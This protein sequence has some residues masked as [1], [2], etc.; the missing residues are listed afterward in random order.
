[1][2]SDNIS[3]LND[4]LKI[5]S[6]GSF[7]AAD[8]LLHCAKLAPVKMREAKVFLPDD[9][10]KIQENPSVSKMHTIG[11]NR[12]VCEN[13]DSFSMARKIKAKKPEEDVLVINFANPVHPG[14]GVKKGSSAQEEDL[15]RKSSLLLSL[16]SDEAKKYYD[17]NKSMNTYM[18]SDAIILSPYVE[19]FKDAKGN[20][21]EE[22]VVVSVLTCAA[23]MI[24]YG[25][26][27]M[28]QDEYKQMLYNR[29]CGMMTVALEYGYENIVWGAWG[30]GAFGNDAAVMADIFHKAF[31]E[32]RYN[33]VGSTGLFRTVYFA[34]LDRSEDLYNF[35]EF[36]RNFDGDNY[37]KAEDDAEINETLDRI[38]DKEKNLDKIKGCI[39][40]GAIG[41][42]LGYPIEFMLEG[43]IT[44][45]Y[46]ESGIT[47]YDL[48]KS[49][50][51]LFSDDTQM[52]LFT[53][54]GIMVGD[55]RIC[56]RGIGAN[57]SNYVA[58]AYQDWLKTQKVSFKSYEKRTDAYLCRSWLCDVPELFS[59]REP[60]NTCLS[61][62]EL[63][64]QTDQ[65]S[66]G[67]QSGTQP[68]RRR[69][70][71]EQPSIDNPVNDSK[72]CGG[73]MR[74]APLALYYAIDD[75]KSLDREG[76]EIAAITHGHSLGYMPAAVL[77]HIISRIVY[78]GDSKMSLKEIV[79]EAK[80]TVDGI[81]AGDKHLP[82][83]DAIIDK[84]VE[85]SENNKSDLDNI[86]T[87]GE[88]WVAEETLA[89]AIYC[90]LKYQNDFSAGVIAAV[91]HNGDSDSTGAVTGNI[92]GALLGYDR[93]E[94]KWKNNLELSNVL[95]EISV[96]LC[97]GCMMD[98]YGHYRDDDWLRKYIDMQ[99]KDTPAKLA[100]PVFFWK[101]NEENGF[102]SNWYNAPFVIDDFEY[103][104]VEQY[105][106]SQKAKM[107][108]DSKT[109][110]A[111]LKA[112]SPS[113]C[114][115]LGK[116]VKPFVSEE[117]AK[118]RGSVC[119]KATLEKFNQNPN[120]KAMLLA[121]GNAILEEASP[122]DKIWGIGLDADTAGKTSPDK[123]PGE[124][125][126]GRV[127]MLVRAQLGGGDISS[128][129]NSSRFDAM[130]QALRDG[131]I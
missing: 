8:G 117:W 9:I 79:I 74:V 66:R 21:L 7:V 12:H 82:E 49:G 26:E 107:F 122:V 41:D 119:M 50:K 31:D 29:I 42:A 25:L 112:D 90:S 81:F 14:G 101:N 76:A 96:D 4:T 77:T 111:I 92:L 13:T 38:E 18:G 88:G 51:A 27:G 114:K 64:E 104:N 37:Y 54:N 94:D 45:Q 68:P 67:C 100:E 44:G 23:P 60:G 95:E 70:P 86:H 65:P 36:A 33:K 34:V 129:I 48:G 1:M 15:C 3:M 75:M 78:P 116:A 24:T 109:Y 58:M 52:T 47:E 62:L 72:G 123:W 80:N 19:I 89:I 126:L 16:E 127:L 91:N 56:M 97:H 61:A 39:F 121:T 73:I 83:L 2:R 35:K 87:L 128:I 32:F 103:Q 98:E 131:K 113:E 85:L 120:L 93:I 28:S 105:I 11:R 124:G 63:M 40:G 130:N 69:R 110:T 99:W 102:L 57:P 43:D 59:R 106:M 55:T 5:C 22:S 20:P 118:V 84:A 71:E 46:G 115:K 30:C 125:L 10:K 108:H 53:A 17:Y 6:E